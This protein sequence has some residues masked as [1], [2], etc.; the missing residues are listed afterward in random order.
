VQIFHF[1]AQSP[2]GKAPSG[3]FAS[4]TRSPTGSR[5]GVCDAYSS[6]NADL[7]A[8]PGKCCARRSV[9]EEPIPC[10]AD[11]AAQRIHP[12]LI[13]RAHRASAERRD[14]RSAAAEICPRNIVLGPNHQAANLRA[15]TGGAAE[16]S[17][18]DAERIR[19]WKTNN[20][21]V[22]DACDVL[23]R[24][25]RPT[26]LNAEIAAG[27]TRRSRH[28]SPRRYSGGHSAGEDGRVHELIVQADAKDLTVRMPVV[29]NLAKKGEAAAMAGRGCR[30]AIGN[31][32]LAA[33]V[34]VEIFKF[35]GPVS[36]ECPLR[37]A[38]DGPSG[39]RSAEIDRVLQVPHGEEVG[40]SPYAMS[41]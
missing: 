41:P 27:P 7:Y 30:K 38:A 5:L 8:F 36:P 6:C 21:I 25:P 17:T 33:K 4:G 35:G 29:T 10:E 22:R 1:Q 20:G 31:P 40:I 12:F 9:D 11:A 39:S 32:A 37:A 2:T 14:I 26:A 24:A 15:A 23:T 18:V 34:I 13:G 28:G 19:D 3:P 16:H